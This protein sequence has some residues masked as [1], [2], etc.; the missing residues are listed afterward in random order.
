LL[1]PTALSGL[2][3]PQLPN[4]PLHGGQFTDKEG[5]RVYVEP[6][7]AAWRTW[8]LAAGSELRPAAPPD[9]S[10]M[11]AELDQ[12]HAL[13]SQRDSAAL[14]RV[15]Y[16]DTGDP[17]YRWNEMAL[18]RFA[19]ITAPPGQ[20]G[21]AL[22][23][24]AIYDATVATWDAKYTYD[25]P[26][27]N[28]LD[29]TLTTVLADPASPSYPSERAVVAGAASTILA[30]LFPDEKGMFSDSAEQ[31]GQSRLVAGVEFPSDVSTGLELGRAVAARV[32]QRAMADGSDAVWVVS[33]QVWALGPVVPISVSARL[34]RPGLE[35]AAI[36]GSVRCRAWPWTPR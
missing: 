14:D 6:G 25:R 2:S 8:V 19:Q 32:I 13:E 18:S 3:G 21:M 12:L 34:P 5:A 31:A 33:R 36:R 26:H 10:A 24:V 27:P 9:Q 17:A 35:L 28:E 15:S 16:W 20:R 4:Y 1:R 29:P 7:A 30:Y 22:L 23:S 11:Q